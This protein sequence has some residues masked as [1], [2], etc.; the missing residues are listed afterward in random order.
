LAWATGSL[1]LLLLFHPEELLLL[2]LH[3]SIRGT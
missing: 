3:A 2:G 1:L